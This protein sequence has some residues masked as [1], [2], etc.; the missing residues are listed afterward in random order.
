MA[1]K[2]TSKIVLQVKLDENKIPESLRWTAEDGGVQ[3]Q[4]AKA[5]FLS[6]W[7]SVNKESLRIDLWTKDMAVDEMKLFFHQTLLSMS[8]TF[9]RATQ[10][11]KMTDTMKDFCDYFAEKL[12]LNKK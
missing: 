2:Q 12:E 5:L 9:M 6:V 11:Q 4:A 10:D 7:D 1:K 8:D 3:D